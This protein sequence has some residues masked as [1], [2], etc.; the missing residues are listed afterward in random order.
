MTNRVNRVFDLIEELE[1]SSLKIII[2]KIDFIIF[3]R[4]ILESNK[5]LF[6]ISDEIQT[7]EIDNK[8]L[9]KS[10]TY[11][12]SN[13][14]GSDL[15]LS[16]IE[17]NNE[18]IANLNKTKNNLKNKIEKWKDNSRN[19]YFSLIPNE[20]LRILRKEINEKSKYFHAEIFQIIG[21]I[22]YFHVLKN[23]KY[24]INK[25]NSGY[26]SNVHYFE[27]NPDETT[28]NYYSQLMEQNEKNKSKFIKKFE[29]LSIEFYYLYNNV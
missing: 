20:K 8:N 9:Y 22:V 24:E 26:A 1:Q 10:G 27:N 19:E 5:E 17:W 2:S 29:L 15:Y 4:L 23:C 25:L 28:R 6:K 7:Y 3:N 16:V 18:T 12:K 13:R 21:P 11:E 14:G